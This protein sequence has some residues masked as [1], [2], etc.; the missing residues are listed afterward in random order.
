MMSRPRLWAAMAV[1]G[2]VAVS[3]AGC[4]R[5]DA[6]SPSS[7]PANPSTTSPSG[8][9]SYGGEDRPRA[10]TTEG[11]GDHWHAAIGF[12]VCGTFLPDVSSSTDPLGIHTHADGVVHVHP[13]SSRSSGARATLEVFFDS[14]D[15]VATADTLHVPGADPKRNGDPCGDQP[16]TVQVKVWDTRSPDDAGRVVT[17]DPGAIRLTDSQ[18]I[19]IAFLP[20]GSDIPKPPSE[21]RLDR[22]ADV[23]PTT[24]ARSSG[25]VSPP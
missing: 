20:A 25:I 13:F 6:P 2:A 4:T 10:A 16:A 18:L 12:D 24:S 3:Q 8:E 5:E 21:P 1:A 14:A 9:A 19:T 7:S 23:P 11:P 22:L 15:I 17:G